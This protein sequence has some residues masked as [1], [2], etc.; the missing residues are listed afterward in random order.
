MKNSPVTPASIPAPQSNDLKVDTYAVSHSTRVSLFS[1]H[2]LND[3]LCFSCVDCSEGNQNKRY[4]LFLITTNKTKESLP[5][6]CKALC[7]NRLESNL[8]ES[9]GGFHFLI[10]IIG[11]IVYFS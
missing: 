8:P 6:L 1:Q 4:L 9:G 11:K 2:I 7:Q 5:I 3:I 10:Q